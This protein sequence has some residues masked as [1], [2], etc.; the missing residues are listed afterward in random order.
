M[1]ARGPTIQQTLSEGAEPVSKSARTPLVCRDQDP[2][3]SLENS[4]KPARPARHMTFEPG[5]AIKRGLE[6]VTTSIMEV[7]EL[8]PA[9]V[10]AAGSGAAGAGAVFIKLFF[11]PVLPRAARPAPFTEFELD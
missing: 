4:T 7:V 9:T 10:P 8:R 1:A 11:L 3:P 6:T 2:P 5:T